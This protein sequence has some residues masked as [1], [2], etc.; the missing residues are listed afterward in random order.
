MSELLQHFPVSCIQVGRND[1]QLFN[2]RD[3]RQLAE[4]IRQDGL[5]QPIVVTPA[6]GGY[7]LV[8]GERRLRAVR[9]LGWYAVPAII[10]EMGDEQASRTM[11]Q[12]NLMRV[13]LNPIE[14]ARAY[15]ERI[16][17]F[18]LSEADLAEWAAIPVRRVRQ[19]LSLLTLRDDVQALVATGQ[20]A[21]TVAAEMVGLDVNRQ[22][23]LLQWLI[24]S[25]KMPSAVLVREKV[26]VLRVQQQQDNSQLFE[27]DPA[28][29]PQSAG[30]QAPTDVLIDNRLPAFPRKSRSAFR[31]LTDYQDELMTAGFHAEAKV[32]GS[33]LL[34]L[35][36]LGHIGTPGS[37][38]K[39]VEAP[40][41]SPSA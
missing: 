40:A 11:L 6:D 19:R 14:E 38:L 30:P 15:R 13:D 36:G 1:R 17:Q 29:G 16:D 9:L 32:V 24:A 18:Q 20:L 39:P 34:G 2:E 33:V 31:A 23:I 37:S 8:A 3:L 25:D 12:E 27:L 26:A 35:F 10:K 22:G 4:S 41:S 28:S 21:P 5:I 7:R